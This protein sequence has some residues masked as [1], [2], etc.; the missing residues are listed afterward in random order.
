MVQ[1]GYVIWGMSHIRNHFRCF[2]P[3]GVAK[4]LR[5]GHGGVLVGCEGRG[6]PFR[7]IVPRAGGSP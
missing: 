5:S 2:I 3:S 1:Y 7:M 6:T 4:A